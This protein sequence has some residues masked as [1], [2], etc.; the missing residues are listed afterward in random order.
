VDRAVV[1]A[2]EQ[3]EVVQRGGAA[4]SPVPHVVRVRPLRTAVATRIGA[5]AIADSECGAD[6]GRDDA[7]APTNVERLAGGI[8]DDAND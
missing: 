8:E 2:A 7:G 1:M 4:V 6:R 5:A 3:D